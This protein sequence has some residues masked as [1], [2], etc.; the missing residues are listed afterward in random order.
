MNNTR[1]GT[2]MI[3]SRVAAGAARRLPLAAFVAVSLG[4][5]AHAQAPAAAPPQAP[6][7]GY[8]AP[9]APRR[10]D[11][12]GPVV[13]ARPAID[14]LATVKR[15]GKL[16]VGMAV[17]TPWV[18][19]DK[20][21]DFIGFSVDLARRL[22]DDLGVPLEIV[23]ASWPGI[24]PDLLDDQF[25][26]IVSGFWITPARAMLVNYTEPTSRV[27]VHLLGGRALA[28]ALKTADD[29]NR[30]NV[31]IV[32][33]GA[34][35][36]ENVAARRFPKA[37]LLKIDINDDP[38]QPVLEGKAHGAIVMT[39]IPGVV[40]AASG[41]KVF[42]PEGSA[43]QE[44]P[45]AAAV[46]KGDADFLNFLNSWLAFQRADGWLAERSDYWFKSSDWLK[47]L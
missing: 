22:A 26:L 16:R 7:Q 21:G 1:T 31:T 33:N 17:A 32:V 25:D 5:L 46:R 12:A 42:L 38:M 29:F 28:G 2:K 14:T 9:D 39:P 11:G 6:A 27:A 44:G 23:P 41:D 3:M 4:A 18:M 20:S 30:P 8:V 37:T 43:L 45:T 35:A 13:Y 15:R 47:L 34:T 40:V 10:A 36:M 19:R 24:V